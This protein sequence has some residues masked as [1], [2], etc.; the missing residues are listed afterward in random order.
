[1]GLSLLLAI[2]LGLAIARRQKNEKVQID[3]LTLSLAASVALFSV[4]IWISSLWAISPYSA[5]HLAMQWSMCLVFFVIMVSAAKSPRMIRSSFIVLAAVVWILGIACAI[6]TW[7]GMPLTDGNSRS[8]L[9][10][11]LRGSGAFGE[12]MAMAAIIFAATAL[13]V[14]RP[15]LALAS[16]ATG[17]LAWM[18][19]VQSLERAPLLGALAG[20]CL[21]VVGAAFAAQCRPRS[22]R[23]LCLLIAA[24]GLVLFFE[25]T[26]SLSNHT[27]GPTSTV[28]RLNQNP[29][30]DINTRSRFLFWGVGWE[31]FREHPLVGVGGNNYEVNYAHS[32]E[33]FSERHPGSSLVGINED[34]LTVYAHNEY[35]QMLAELG[36]V[37]LLLFVLLS[38]L[39]VLT[40]WR[41]LKH[42]QYAMPALGAGSAMLAF[43]ISSGASGSSFR[44]LGSSLLFFFAAANIARIA[45]GTKGPSRIIPSKTVYLSDL[46]FR[47]ISLSACTLVIIIVGVVGAQAGGLMLHGLAQS[48]V[49]PVL[50]EH[51]YSTSLQLYPASAATHFSYGLWLYSKGRSS[52]AVPHLRDAV[53]RGFNSS[54][55]FAYLAG[56]EANAGDLSAAERTLASAVKAY[57]ISVFLL[58]RHAVALA[59]TGRPREAEAE[60]TKAASLNPRAARGWRQLIDNDIDAA[61]LA[62]KQD[63]SIALPG[64]LAPQTAVF[65][66]LKENEQRFPEAINTGWRARMR[67]G[68]N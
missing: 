50:S 55:C 67:A 29:T 15:R 46:K 44:N 49:D 3:F 39:L 32:R 8:D 56:A 63:S 17:I 35:L 38:L 52:E 27:D 9:K 58:V 25:T 37:G 1:L 20:F 59:R 6:E 60:F 16:G 54:I 24:L 22:W 40:F 31:M 13:Y 48:S 42:S 51:Y 4:W 2:G 23:R 19:T 68:A 21:L 34:L 10:P 53:D 64:E 12:M 26:P 66:I 36:V 33:K 30:V 18:A 5:V 62:A 47:R 14:R 61:Y 11:L 57:P 28:A 7:F 41:A 45:A 43:A 65:A